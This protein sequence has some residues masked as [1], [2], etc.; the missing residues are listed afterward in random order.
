MLR[1]IALAAVLAVAI[2]SSAF[3]AETEGKVQSVND[4]DRTLTLDNGATIWLSESV[5]L[6]TVKEGAEVK[7]VYEEKDGKP[8]A[9]SV[10][11]K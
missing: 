3:G 4:A 1:Y 9:T 8:V 7:V 11:V 10:E 5:A 6:D 2:V